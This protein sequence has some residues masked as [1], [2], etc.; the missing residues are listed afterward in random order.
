MMSIIHDDLSV[1]GF[2]LGFFFKAFQVLCAIAVLL[3][4]SAFAATAL[5][6]GFDDEYAKENYLHRPNY[7]EWIGN[8]FCLE[9]DK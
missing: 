6:W 7:F 2:V 4:F 5:A 3:L 8:G 9:G 1:T